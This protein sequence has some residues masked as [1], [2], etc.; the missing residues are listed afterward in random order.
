MNI[1]TFQPDGYFLP[2]KSES[3]KKICNWKK[4]LMG[5]HV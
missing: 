3:I 2:Y 5:L 4:G 1:L